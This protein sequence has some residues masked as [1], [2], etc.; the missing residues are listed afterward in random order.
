MCPQHLFR[1]FQF[2]IKLAAA[3][4][5]QFTEIVH[6]GLQRWIWRHRKLHE[7][8][9]NIPALIRP[10]F[11]KNLIIP[12]SIFP[13]YF[14]LSSSTYLE[15]CFFFFFS[16][17]SLSIFRAHLKTVLKWD[18]NF[19]NLENSG[20]LSKESFQLSPNTDTQHKV[21]VEIKHLLCK[22]YVSSWKSEAPI[23]IRSFLFSSS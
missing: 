5:I 2:T 16:F 11:L 18:E 23:Q 12:I 21:V 19:W 7:V 14:C 3:C 10:C 15:F 13:V 20:S 6:V 4:F 9:Y 8:F 17:S 22:D 1:T